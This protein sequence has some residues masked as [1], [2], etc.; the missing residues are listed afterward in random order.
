[1]PCFPGHRGILLQPS[2]RFTQPVV[3][4]KAV[5]QIFLTM[6][7]ILLAQIQFLVSGSVTT[8]QDVCLFESS[9]FT[10]LLLSC[11]FSSL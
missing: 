3:V 11:L 6:Q 5:L 7:L 8:V 4:Q 9:A 1:M 2:P 10:V